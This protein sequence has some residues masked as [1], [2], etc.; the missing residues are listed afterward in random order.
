M[1]NLQMM[2]KRLEFQGGIRQEDRMI[3]DKYNT[4]LK[5]LNYSYQ[6]CDIQLAQSY[7]S[8]TLDTSGRGECR[9]LINPDKNK[10]DYDNK[11]LSVDYSHNYELGDIIQW[12]GTNTYWIIYLTELTEDAYFRGS[13][14]RCKHQ[15]KFKNENGEVRTTWAAIRGPVETKID[16]IQ[17]NQIR[18]DRPNLSLNILLPLNE[19]TKF[20]FDRYS[21]FLFNG[22]CWRV[23]A[24]DSI[25]MKNV[26]EIN[27]EEYYINLQTDDVQEEIKNGLMIEPVDPTPTSLI[28]GPTFIKPR[29]K[30]IFSA[31]TK[32]TWKVLEDYP[33]C[34]KVISDTEVEVLWNKS[35]S[36]QFTLQWSNDETTDNKIVVVESLF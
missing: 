35:T 18:V 33:V 5:S 3:K 16:S 8:C 10:P 27:A 26:L 24:V 29:I 14:R 25:S 21:D 9:A 15:I 11:I 23:Q 4:F 2:K 31:P 34:L 30:E 17:K 32:G 22:K 20:A 7:K 6:G 13:I 12:V 28:A 1:N 19:D 36:G